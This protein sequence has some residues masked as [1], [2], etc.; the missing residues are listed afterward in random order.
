MASAIILLRSTSK[1]PSTEA[2]KSFA[3]RVSESPTGGFPDS[4]REQLLAQLGQPVLIQI[5][6]SD[7][8]DNTTL[9]FRAFFS[10]LETHDHGK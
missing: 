7:H 2:G 8:I 6:L 4:L 5:E 3:R 10:G 9:K 1:L